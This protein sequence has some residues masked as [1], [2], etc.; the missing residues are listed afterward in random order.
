MADEIQAVKL[1][2]NV[3]IRYE[4]E[5]LTGLA[6]G[7]S[8]TGIQIGGVDKVVIRNPLNGEPYIPGSSLRGKIR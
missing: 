4:I 1:T 5:L 7:G 8:D 2:H 3:F 6:I